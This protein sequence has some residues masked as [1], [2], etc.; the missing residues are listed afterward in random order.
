MGKSKFYPLQ[1]SNEVVVNLCKIDNYADINEKTVIA[2]FSNLAF[3]ACTFEIWSALLNG[4]VLSI[5]PLSDRTDHSRLKKYLEKHKI[6]C[7]FLPT[8][9]FHQLIKSY[10]QT[11]N[12][13]GKIIFGGEQVNFVLLKKYLTFRKDTHNPVVLINGYGPTEATTFTCKHVLTE[14]YNFTDEEDLKSIGTAISNV[15]TYVLDE[16]G[17]PSQEGE[18]YISGIN[19]AAGY[20]SEQYNETSFFAN[21]F[22]STEP[23]IRMY[24]T[25]DKVK[26]LPSGKIVCLGRLDDQVKI[27]GFR[28]HLNEIE[29]ALMQHEAISLAAVTVEMGGASHKLLA[30]YLVLNTKKAIHADE[31]RFFLNQHLPD[32]MLPSKYVIL[33]E[34]PLTLV[35]K[36]DK[37][38]LPNKPQTELYFHI[39][40]SS[41]SMVEERIKNIWQH[42]LN[43]EN[44]DT[45]KNIFELGANSLLLLEA[46]S[47]I[48]SELHTDVQISQPPRC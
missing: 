5:I 15:K 7:L 8:S 30:A 41:D 3:D 12:S 42:L 24:K 9:F 39:D 1:T 38:S 32:Y 46:C 17:N 48:N 29:N 19:L 6:N 4:G 18:L 43:T 37:N 21:P 25:G 14:Q 45:Q 20:L 34:L 33:D 13:V 10:P 26:L 16:Q 31:L 35:G 22:I 36:V 11:L 23:F 44:I 2:Q 27:G 28:I 47:R 40:S